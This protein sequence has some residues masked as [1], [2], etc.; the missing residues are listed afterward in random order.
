MTDVTIAPGCILHWDGFILSDGSEGHKYFVIVG[1]QPQKHYLAIIATSKKK[2]RDHTPGGNPSGGWY[3]IPGGQRDWFKLDTWLLFDAPEELSASVLLDL[4][5]K[6]KIKPV[7]SLR[8]DISNAICNCM[9][10]CDDVSEYHKTLLGPPVQA[11][12]KN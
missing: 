1:A 8:H 3:H 2:H 10:K 4:K 7:G 12:K 6:G 5:L 11:P 9:R